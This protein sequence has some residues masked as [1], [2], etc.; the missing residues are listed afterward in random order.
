MDGGIM[1]R[2]MDG[3]YVP[4][5][6]VE[7]VVR[8]IPAPFEIGW[9]GSDRCFSGEIDEVAVYDKALSVTEIRKHFE[10]GTR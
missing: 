9:S 3:E 7:E 5:I 2:Y 6:G 1:I 4:G 8:P 10:E